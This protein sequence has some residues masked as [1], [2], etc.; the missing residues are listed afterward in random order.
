MT[1][2]LFD[3]KATRERLGGIGHTKLY[4]LWGSGELGSVY[5]GKRRFSSDAQIADYIRNREQAAREEAAS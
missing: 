2:Q 3:Q 1:A 5:V 4:E